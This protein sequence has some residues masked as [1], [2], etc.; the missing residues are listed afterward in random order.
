MNNKRKEKRFVLRAFFHLRLIF[1]WILDLALDLFFFILGRR[2]SRPILLRLYSFLTIAAATLSVI[3]LAGGDLTLE[4]TMSESGS[5]SRA[6]P[7]PK[8]KTPKTAP[9]SREDVA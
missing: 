5:S 9:G 4:V 7:A 6:A 2:R 1:H 3:V 8:R